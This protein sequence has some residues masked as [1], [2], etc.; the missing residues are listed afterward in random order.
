MPTG[1]IRNPYLQLRYQIEIEGV[2]VAGFSEVTGI[3]M[4]TEFLE[5]R[6]GGLNAYIHKLPG[7]TLVSNLVL[8][9]GLT[10]SASLWEWY[11]N[12]VNGDFKRKNGAV[13]LQNE[14]R[15]AVWRWNFVQG[16]PVS[17][18]GPELRADSSLLAVETLVIAHN[19]LIKGG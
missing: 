11:R 8:K 7:Q 5:F 13:I 18:Q 6:E 16:Y 17:W 12:V 15:E 9:R 1:P 2:L 3:R 4:T 14:Q 19:G 10:D